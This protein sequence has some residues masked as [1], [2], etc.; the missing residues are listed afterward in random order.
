MLKYCISYEWHNLT[1]KKDSHNVGAL[2]KILNL[3][4]IYLV[5]K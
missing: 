1:Y 3:I 4:Q 5:K 2:C